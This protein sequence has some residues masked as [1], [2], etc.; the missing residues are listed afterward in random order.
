MRISPFRLERYLELYEFTAKYILGASD[1]ESFEIGEILSDEEI[2]ELKSFRL[3]YSEAQGSLSLRREVSNLFQVVDPEDL[4]LCVPQ[5]GIFIT[6][7]ALLE[8]GDKVIVQVP[9]YQSLCEMPKVLGCRVLT[10]EPNRDKTC[11]EWNLDFLRENVDRKTKLIVINSPQNPT[12]QTF[13]KNEYLEILDIARRNDCYVFSDEM[14]RLLEHDPQDRLPIGADVYEKCV[15][16]S[17]MSKTFGL[18][19][20]RL[21]WLASRDK[22]TLR[23]IVEFKD[24][25]TI[26]NNALGEY[27]AK[28]ALRKKD[29]LLSRNHNIVTSNLSVLDSFFAGHKSLFGWFKPRAGSIAFVQTKFRMVVEDFCEDLVKKKDV[30]LVPSTKFGYGN[31]HFRLGFGRKNMREGIELL[32]EYVE[33]NLYK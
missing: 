27:V 14:Y 16:L 10:W 3:G 1:C 5:E 12:G 28:I 32:E 26:S 11:W 18:G 33:E 13:N 29:I 19:G 6:M 15:S 21:G 9:C 23:R 2:S 8:A 20:L 4:V 22:G 7:N 30:L 31:H 25:T 24:Y 17:G